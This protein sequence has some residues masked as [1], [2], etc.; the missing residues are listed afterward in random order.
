MDINIRQGETVS[1]GIA[2]IN[3][4]GARQPVSAVGSADMVL[5]HATGTKTTIALAVRPGTDDVELARTSGQSAA[6]ATGD[7]TFRISVT[8]LDA[9]VRTYPS[10]DMPPGTLGVVAL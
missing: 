2:L 10:V 5:T 6:M 1:C 7:Y 8:M 9:T 4:G 3:S